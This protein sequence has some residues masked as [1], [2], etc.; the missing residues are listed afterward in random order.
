[1]PIKPT[2]PLKLE[3][4]KTRAYD[5]DKRMSFTFWRSRENHEIGM[6]GMHIG[7]MSDT[8]TQEEWADTFQRLAE[9]IRKGPPTIAGVPITHID[10]ELPR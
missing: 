6:A 1:M 7:L 3:I 9:W 8:M 10:M 5:G 2:E 4:I